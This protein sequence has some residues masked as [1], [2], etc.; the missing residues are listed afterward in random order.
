[1]AS[2]AILPTG[3]LLLM[4]L[5]RPALAVSPIL[6]TVETFEASVRAEGGF[7]SSGKH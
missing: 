7:G 2:R 1:M 4:L 6:W 3:F 5:P